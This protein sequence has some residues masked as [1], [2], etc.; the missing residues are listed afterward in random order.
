MSDSQ[1]GSFGDQKQFDVIIIG[2]GPAGYTAGIYTS[3]ANLRTLV[4]SGRVPDI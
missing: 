2:S 1:S 4:I 3:R